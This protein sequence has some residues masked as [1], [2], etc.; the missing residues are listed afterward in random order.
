MRLMLDT[1]VTIDFMLS[2]EPFFQDA[3]KLM[4]LGY[5][6]EAE[7][8]ISGAQVND[9]FYMLT[10]GGK[11]AYNDEAKQHIK[12]LRQCVHIYRVGEQEV[13][14]TLNSTWQDLE[15]ACLY[16]S[17]LSLKADFII[18]RNQQ[19]FSL[20]SIKAFDAAEFLTY[21]EEQENLTYQEIDLSHEARL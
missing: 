13:D 2:R 14:A 3:K 16:Y 1:N 17:A 20:S 21:L 18:T 4:L 15:D 9:L 10:R 11:P 7:L 8:W 6:Q 5:L 12:K 19:D